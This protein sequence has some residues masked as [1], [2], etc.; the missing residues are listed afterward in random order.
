MLAYCL[1]FANDLAIFGLK[2]WEPLEHTFGFIL[3]SFDNFKVNIAKVRNHLDHMT[4]HESG[5]LLHIKFALFFWW[6][7]ISPKFSTAWGT[8]MSWI[9][10]FFIELLK[11]SRV[12]WEKCLEVLMQLINSLFANSLI[13]TSSYI[14]LSRLGLFFSSNENKVELFKLMI[15]DFLVQSQIWF[16]QFNLITL[17]VKIKIYTLA[18]VKVF[19]RNWAND[20]LSWREE[21]WPLSPKMLNKNSHESLHGS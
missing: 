3:W 7:L 9:P 11:S 6:T 15:S 20:T 16:V 18:I 4:L 12:L 19:L 21:E 13:V 2:E 1:I 8:K 5:L 14:N 10:C 17:R